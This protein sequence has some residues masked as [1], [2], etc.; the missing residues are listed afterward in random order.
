MKG[1]KQM[2]KIKGN[3][4]LILGYREITKIGEKLD[5]RMDFGILTL[6]EEKT[7]EFYDEDKEIAFLIIRGK[8]KL[9]YDNKT[10]IAQRDSF[11][12]ENPEV[13]HVPRRIRVLITGI[14][15]ISEISIIKTLNERDFESKIYLKEECSSEERGKGTLKETSTRIVRT[16]FDYSNAN[17][18]N[19]VIG[20]VINFPGKWSSYPPHHHPQPEIYYYKFENEKGYGFSQVGEDVFKVK[21]NDTIKIF[22][23][24]SH[25]QV[26]APGYPM[27]YIWVIRHIENNPYISPIYE[28]DHI[29]VNNNKNKIWPDK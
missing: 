11:L 10:H 8:I 27:Y 23:G 29:W 26:A 14:A 15:H 28:E 5:T 24:N 17:Y 22:Q 9:E 21:N 2:F 16:V 20:E 6:E 13:L 19:L 12:D 1:M 4:E 7:F 3:S 25:P 18:S